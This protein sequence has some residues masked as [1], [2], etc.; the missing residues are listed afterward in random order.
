MLKKPIWLKK[1][2]SLGCAHTQMETDL[3]AR[4]LHTICQEGC[5]PNQGECFSKKEASFLIM[6]RVCTRSCRFC[7][8][9]SGKP[10]ALDPD[11]PDRL[12]DVVRELGLKYVVV[13]S[14]TRDD[15]PD[16]G[17]GHYA[18]VIE[19][20]RQKCPGVCIEVLIPDFQGSDE[21]LSIVVNKH[22]EVLNHNV[23]TVPRLYKTVRPQAD[24]QRSVEL[25]S[26]AKKIWGG[27][28]TKTGIMV[29]L[30]ETRDEVFSVMDDLLRAG[31][32]I[33]TIGQYLQP[34]SNHYDVKDYIHPD[35]FS[36]YEN[37]ARMKG[38]K[39]VVSSPF[40]RSSYR[41][42]ELY[43]IASNPPISTNYC[44]GN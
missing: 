39:G 44:S 23:E 1:R 14:V 30:G 19:R 28:T 2:L 25:L 34:S 5:C 4:R 20:L 7:A 36:A 43:H 12:A 38:F 9:E 22:P 35:I 10:G 21:S 17:A 40:V 13:T 41:A 24:Y 42:G 11:E 37:E 29:G 26:Q 8:V 3:F 18:G 27:I 16:G 6:G 33:L 31:C 32:D 15:L